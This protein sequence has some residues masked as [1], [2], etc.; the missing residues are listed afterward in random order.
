[1]EGTGY[2]PS[3]CKQFALNRSPRSRK[4]SQYPSDSSMTQSEDTSSQ[5]SNVNS[6]DTISVRF[7]GPPLPLYHPLGNLALS[8]PG[9]DP[10]DFGLPSNINIDGSDNRLR[11]NGT[12]RRASSRARRPAAKLRDR[13]RD[14]GEEDERLSAV[15]DATS[16]VNGTAAAGAAAAAVAAIRKAA[17]PQVRSASP[18]KRRAAAGGGKRRRKD[19]DDGDSAYPNPPKRSRTRATAVGAVAS[20]LAGTAMAVDNADVDASV[21]PD[22]PEADEPRVDTVETQEQKPTTRSRR[23]PAAPKRRGSSASETT[24][25]SLSV[26]IATNTKPRSATAPQTEQLEPDKDGD[27]PMAPSEQPEEKEAVPSS[28]TEKEG[29]LDQEKPMELSTPPGPATP[30]DEAMDLESK[31]GGSREPDKA[32]TDFVIET[33]DITS[34]GAQEHPSPTPP[35]PTAEAVSTESRKSVPPV[36]DAV[37]KAVVSPL[38]NDSNKATDAAAQSVSDSK[39]LVSEPFILPSKP[40]ESSVPE[41]SVLPSKSSPIPPPPPTPPPRAEPPP[42]KVAKPPREE[43]KEEGELSE[44]G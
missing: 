17:E 38:A 12:S 30:S 43:E 29:S 23:K 14:N 4:A 40:A 28:R 7:S 8:L 5:K 31:S 19:L 20:P 11:Q 42:S 25:T 16:L 9:L 22:V 33:K 35:Q 2:F 15:V 27:V 39:A 34:G 21:A 3:C 32:P 41:P 6:R 44:D 18:R 37:D 36:A 24:T 10:S 13:D 1:M 26:S